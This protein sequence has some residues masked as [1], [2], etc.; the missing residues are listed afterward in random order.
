MDTA[1]R[2][3]FTYS[4]NVEQMDSRRQE[5][6]VPLT[7]VERVEYSQALDRISDGI[8]EKVIEMERQCAEG[9]RTKAS[10]G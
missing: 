8:L 4:N 2:S 5:F 9:S 1:M 7:G 3:P 10:N 6:D